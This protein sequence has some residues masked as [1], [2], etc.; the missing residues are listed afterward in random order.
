MIFSCF[1][2]PNLVTI[3]PRRRRCGL[4]SVYFE[5][6]DNGALNLWFSRDCDRFWFVSWGRIIVR[7]SL[8]LA[9]VYSSTVDLQ[10]VPSMPAISKG[11]CY[12]VVVHP[13]HAFISLGLMHWS[14]PVH[15]IH[16]CN[17][18]FCHSL[19]LLEQWTSLH[20]STEFSFKFPIYK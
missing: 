6:H 19:D 18:C 14:V 12:N 10:G 2:I 1:G 5:W 4:R 8:L 17:A 15:R 16:R 9:E 7:L 3:W 13:W 11:V 20:L